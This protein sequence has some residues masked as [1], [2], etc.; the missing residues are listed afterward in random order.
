M[1]YDEKDIGSCLTIDDLYCFI[2]GPPGGDRNSGLEAHLAHCDQCRE[3]LAEVLKLLHPETPDPSAADSPLSDAE[4]D[5]TLAMIRAVDRRER[6]VKEHY[7]WGRWLATA[8]A[9]IILIAA[10]AGAYWFYSYY[11]Q[12]TLFF[13]H[14]KAALEECYTGK[15]PGDLRLDLPFRPSATSRATSNG[16]DLERARNG[17]ANTLAFRN[18]I[19]AH[20]GL[21]AVYLDESKFARAREQ[22]QEVL[23]LSENHFQA[24]LG[25]GVTH[26]EDGRIAPDAA[27]QADRFKQALADFNAAIAQQPQSLEARYNRIMALNETGRLEEALDEIGIYFSR[28]SSSIW[29]VKLK[30]LE[31]NIRSAKLA[32]MKSGGNP[33]R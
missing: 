7:R 15:S 22:F 20:L 25:R 8:A 32:E 4:I 11:Y 28:D 16:P 27:Q 5:Q 29:A 24:L 19:N 30:E 31:K 21:A 17:F 3:E 12:P 10:G 23:G 9:A 18:D 33:D 2:A 14:A 26:Y 13:A 6:R 1:K